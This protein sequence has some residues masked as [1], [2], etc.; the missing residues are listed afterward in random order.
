LDD[1]PLFEPI[2]RLMSKPQDLGLVRGERW[3]NLS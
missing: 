3:L 1:S 2:F